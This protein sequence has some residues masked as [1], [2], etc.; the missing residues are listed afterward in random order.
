MQLNIKLIPGNYM[1][2]LNNFL[3]NL[4]NGYT[5]KNVSKLYDLAG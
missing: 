2:I 1:E 5:K 4:F 3:P